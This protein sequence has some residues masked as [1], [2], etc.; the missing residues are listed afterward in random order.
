MRRASSSRTRT[1]T[2]SASSSTRSCT[3]TVERLLRFRQAV[4]L[5]ALNRLL[6]LGRTTCGDDSKVEAGLTSNRIAGVT[7]PVLA[8]YGEF[9][10]FLATAEFLEAHLPRCRTATVSGAKHRAPEENP[11]DFLR[12]LQEF[13]ACLPRPAREGRVAD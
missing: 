7:V 2:T 11:E 5:P 13:L 1:G 12:L 4:G 9:S 10:P 3:S 6:R 8:L